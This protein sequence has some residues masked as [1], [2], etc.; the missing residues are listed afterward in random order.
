M[1]LDI[2]GETVF[3]K[4]ILVRVDIGPD[5]LEFFDDIFGKDALEIVPGPVDF[6]LVLVHGLFKLNK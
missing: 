2:L 6:L 4:L 5:F 1:L 3:D